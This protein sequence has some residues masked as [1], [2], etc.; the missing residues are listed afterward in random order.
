M[1]Y[2]DALQRYKNLNELYEFTAD[3]LRQLRQ[4]IDKIF[5]GSEYKDKVTIVAAGS[6]GRMEASPESD[7]DVYILFDSDR[8]AQD[9]IPTELEQLQNCISKHVPKEAGDT[10]TFGPNAYI[11][12]SELLS[13]I[14]GANDSNELMTRRLLFL[15]EGTWLFGKERFN[16][17]RRELLERYVN[18]TDGDFKIPRFLLNDIIRYYRTITTD[19]EHKVTDGQ[20]SWGL[21][22]VK[23]RFSRKA[24]Y[25]GG[26][27]AVAQATDVTR[28]NRL[29]E[30]E[31]WFELPGLERL[32]SAAQAAPKEALNTL[33]IE[34]LELYEAFLAVVSDPEKREILNNLDR[35]DRNECA[36]YTGLR[37]KADQLTHCLDQWLKTAYRADH[38]IHH[39]LIF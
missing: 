26:I 33:A 5:K 21:R 28:D 4:D 19:F 9:V 23:L 37:A 15:L 14:G 6:F 16:R 3:K 12:F 10:G 18:E 25:F 8:D 29:N 2:K 39:A 20:K 34:V 36:A 35:I 17:Y 22:Q 30:L 24:L 7:L 13:N 11:R 31:R 32:H 1:N 38:P 27:I